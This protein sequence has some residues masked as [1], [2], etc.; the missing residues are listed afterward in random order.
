MIICV[1]VVY[2]IICCFSA[3]GFVE[4]ED[5]RDAEVSKIGV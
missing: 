1:D 3:Y 5:R 4:F 2:I